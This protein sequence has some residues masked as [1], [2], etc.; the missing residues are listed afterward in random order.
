MKSFFQT[1]RQRSFLSACRITGKKWSASVP[2]LLAALLAVVFYSCRDE[3]LFPSASVSEQNSNTRAEAENTG[4]E[5]LTSPAYGYYKPNR[6]IPLVGEGRVINFISN[7][8]ISVIGDDNNIECLIDDDIE[9]NAV[10]VSGL[11]KVNAGVPIFSVR[12]VNRIYYATETEK[13]KVGFV[14]NPGESVLDLSVLKSF[15]IQTL[16][17]GEVQESS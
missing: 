4:L 15:Y 8:L 10:T 2:L 3:D 17:K 14:Y 5:A 12:D 9:T 1:S 6:C 7:S 16:L 13:I 11:T